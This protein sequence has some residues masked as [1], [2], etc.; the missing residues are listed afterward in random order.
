[1]LSQPPEFSENGDCHRAVLVGALVLI[2]PLRPV[3]GGLWRAPGAL[4]AGEAVLH[5]WSFPRVEE[6]SWERLL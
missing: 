2:R 4:V 5:S 3:K 1:M 6:E